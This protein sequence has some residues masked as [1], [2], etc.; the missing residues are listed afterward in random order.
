MGRERRRMRRY[1]LDAEITVETVAA[2]TIDLSAN[3]MLFESE[4]QFAPGDEVGFVFPLEHTAP[5]GRVTCTAHV[6]RVEPRGTWFA[7][8][9]TYEPTVFNVA[10]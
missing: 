5:G 7:V 6:V 10:T 3:G 9:V 4:R 8:A 1:R 2:R